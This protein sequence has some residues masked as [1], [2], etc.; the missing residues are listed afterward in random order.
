RPTERR[1]REESA[2]RQPTSHSK[3]TDSNK[4]QF[5]FCCFFIDS[6]VAFVG[7]VPFLPYSLCLLPV[8]LP[9]EPL[10]G[11]GRMSPASD[12]KPCSDS[13]D[14]H[15]FATLFRVAFVSKCTLLISA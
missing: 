8:G 10:A 15:F 4:W 6:I 7:T 5:G 1:H 9:V 14:K 12:I 13:P 2:N 11:D 3:L